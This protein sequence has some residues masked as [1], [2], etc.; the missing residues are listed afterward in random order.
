[1]KPFF[2]YIFTRIFHSFKSFV[3]KLKEDVQFLYVVIKGAVVE[4]NNHHKRNMEYGSLINI[5]Y[6]LNPKI[7]QTKCI[8]ASDTILIKIPIDIIE[9]KIKHHVIF[10]F[11]LSL[12]V[13]IIILDIGRCL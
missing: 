9:G 7:Y 2:M 12:F 11:S 4:S 10:F 1:M 6:L 3:Y 13:T 5:G 8:S